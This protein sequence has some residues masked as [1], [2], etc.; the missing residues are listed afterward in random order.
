MAKVLAR[1]GDRTLARAAARGMS[2]LEILIVIVIVAAL[3]RLAVSF[4]TVRNPVAQ[5]RTVGTDL[6][7]ELRFTRMLAIAS[8]SPQQLTFH[9]NQ[10]RWEGPRHHHGTY[11]KEAD[12]RITGP[13]VLQT[14]SRDASV[15]FFP[16]GASTGGRIDLQIGQVIWRLDVIW[17]TGE[18]QSHAVQ[19]PSP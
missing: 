14:P 5:L 3:S 15:R 19:V 17:V 11:P 18:V 9:L 10:H 12:I 6:A 8:G 1:R 7:T 16:D 4:I 2:L 13:L